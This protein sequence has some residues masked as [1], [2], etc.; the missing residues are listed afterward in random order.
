MFWTGKKLLEHLPTLFAQRDREIANEQGLEAGP[1]ESLLEVIAEQVG[2]MEHQVDQAYD[3]AFVETCEAWV[4]PY[5]GE[6]LGIS[7]L[8]PEGM[9]AYRPRAYV[10]NTLAYRR[11][12]GTPGM[13][14]QL[15]RDTTGWHAR[16]TE[17]FFLLAQTRHLNRNGGRP[18]CPDLRHLEPLERAGSAF[19]S[20]HR[21]PDIRNIDGSHCGR[22]NIPSIGIHLWPIRSFAPPDATGTPTVPVARFAVEARPETPAESVARWFLHPLGAP[23]PLYNRPLSRD[24]ASGAEI[25]ALAGER[26]VPLPLRRLPL[27]QETEALRQ[28]LADG[29]PTPPQAYLGDERPVLQLFVDDEIDPVPP[30][31]I[32][33]VDFSQGF[34]QP[35]ALASYAPADGGPAIDL[36]VRAAVDPVRGQVA[37]SPG[38]EPSRLRAVYAYGFSAEIGG[39]PYDRQSETRPADDKPL[40]WQ[41]GV[42]RLLD[43]IPDVIVDS[44]REAIS[45]WNAR[46]A[47][48]RGMICVLDSMRYEE[49]L[50]GPRRVRIPENSHLTLIAADWPQQETDPGVFE[51]LTGDYSPNQLRPHLLGNLDVVGTAPSGSENPGAFHLEG[52]LVEGRC[53]VRPG[54]LGT[55]TLSH[56]TI[57]HDPGALLEINAATDA[58]NQDLRVEIAKSILPGIEIATDNES[59]VLSDSIVGLPED[60]ASAAVTAESTA[61]RIDR[62]TFWGPV[63]CRQIDASEAIFMATVQSGRTQVGCVRFSY[64]PRDSNAP[65][66][67]KCQPNTAIEA[68][69]TTEDP[70][71][72]D[73][74]A[75]RVR[76]WFH[77]GNPFDPAFC[78]LHELAAAEIRAG[79]ENGREMG[80][81][82]ALEEP[83]RE[84]FLAATLDEFLRAGMQAGRITETTR[85]PVH[86][87]TT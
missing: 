82:N 12:K 57:A 87:V 52:F 59:L 10:A 38:N 79:G 58:T 13:L 67:Y 77:S 83:L 70:A 65:P 74:I 47:G 51:R 39:G 34:P 29:A 61:V 49:D 31:T 40:D 6:L 85:N 80:A 9:T 64:L 28:A 5:L 35:D 17:Y 36:P 66:Q 60:S 1:L 3:N 44:L 48:T 4:L 42:S 24:P 43:P 18:F 33:I 32:R 25:T 16:V 55:F 27:H 71:E 62:G 63:R 30:E 41:I 2:E 23:I 86:Y 81:F 20:T 45:Q 19:S 22:H 84:R 72:A 50:T 68:A 53:R 76:P 75:Q 46:P 54:H 21:F 11:R 14:E 7:V 69:G 56:A 15:A 78:R 73:A 37:F 26:D 8:P